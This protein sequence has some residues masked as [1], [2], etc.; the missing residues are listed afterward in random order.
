MAHP[1]E[2]KCD[3][4]SI[5]FKNM[6]YL[7]KHMEMLHQETPHL[8]MERHFTTFQSRENQTLK[9]SKIKK[10]NSSKIFDCSECGLVFSMKS[11]YSTHI[12]KIPYIQYQ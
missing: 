3:F 6:E 7:D 10:E 4:C 2:E 9:N 8:R 1:K 11:D 5:K 12:K